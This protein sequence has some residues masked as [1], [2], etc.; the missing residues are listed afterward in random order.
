MAIKNIDI[1]C[2]NSRYVVLNKPSGVLCNGYT[3]ACVLPQIT[4]A[5]KKWNPDRKLNP[6][7]F[8]LVQRLDRYVSGGM[9]VSRNKKFTK[10]LNQSLKGE[11]DSITFTR[12]YVG[13]IKC[14]GLKNH[15]KKIDSSKSSLSIDPTLSFG[16]I[17]LGITKHLSPKARPSSTKFKILYDHLKYVLNDKYPE[18]FNSYIYPVIFEL[19]TG[20]KNQ[21]RDHCLAAFGLPLLNDDKFL[22]LKHRQENPNSLLF[23]SNQIGL[24]SGFIRIKDEEYQFPIFFEP[25][26]EL[27]QGFVDELGNFTEGIQN[28]LAKPQS[29][30]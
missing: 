17:S 11:D 30:L 4:L 12:R 6:K 23:R 18:L 3:P 7:Q 26:R 24:H 29:L 15:L 20:R 28:E 1:I 27:W 22:H 25:D 13:L 2:Q 21:I 5:F 9:I 19:K 14:N 8:Q 16:V 10:K